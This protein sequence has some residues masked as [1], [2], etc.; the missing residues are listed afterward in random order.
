[1]QLKLGGSGHFFDIAIHQ[2]DAAGIVLEFE[3]AQ[4]DLDIAPFIEQSF[5][6]ILSTLTLTDLYEDS[7]RLFK[8]LTG[9][10]RV[11]I[12]RF[13]QEGHGQVIAERRNQGL[14]P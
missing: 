12:Y 14:E 13:D 1:M 8:D 2:S 9:Y 6:S 3:L 10:D 7:A 5:H 4:E 11:M